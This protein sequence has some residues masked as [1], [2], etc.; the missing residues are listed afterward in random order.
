M[1]LLYI[2]IYIYIYIYWRYF[3][4]KETKNFHLCFLVS[5]SDFYLHPNKFLLSF[6]HIQSREAIGIMYHGQVILAPVLTFK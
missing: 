4:L 1:S 5:S 6:D 3:V 2:Y